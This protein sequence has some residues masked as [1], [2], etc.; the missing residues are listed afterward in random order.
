M[1]ACVLE[2]ALAPFGPTCRMRVCISPLGSGGIFMLADCEPGLELGNNIGTKITASAISTTAPSRRFFKPESMNGYR[3]GRV[4]VERRN[5]AG[6]ERLARASPLERRNSA[7]AE[8]YAANFAQHRRDHMKAAERDDA[9]FRRC[10]HPRSRQRRRDVPVLTA[11]RCGQRGPQ[12]C[13][14]TLDR[15]AARRFVVQ[16]CQIPIV[17]APA[18]RGHHALDVLVCKR[19]EDRAGFP[20][21]GVTIQPARKFTR[22]LR[23][24]ADIDDEVRT[25]TELLQP[26]PA[27]APP[28]SH[29]PSVRLRAPA[30]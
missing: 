9:V 30:N 24:V 14:Q 7:C 18:Q 12:A 22:G 11:R 15:L 23:V 26:A 3:E 1:D 29:F 17:D 25:L 6:V 19:T 16:S 20:R 4:G 21:N 5:E 2:P 27:V 10:F 28:I 8:L 13:R